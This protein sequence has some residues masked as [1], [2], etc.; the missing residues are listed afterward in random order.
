MPEATEERDS[1]KI[2]LHALLLATSATDGLGRGQMPARA[3]LARANRELPSD[4][5]ES[6]R[7]TEAG[8]PF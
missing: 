3:L 1:C 8:V 7:A 2:C 4:D 6:F 5:Q